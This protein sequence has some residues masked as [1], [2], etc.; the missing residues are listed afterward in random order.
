GGILQGA[1]VG[2]KDAP[3]LLENVILRTE[4][5][6]ENVI[7]GD[8]VKFGPGVT[9]GPNVR[10]ATHPDCT[11]GSKKYNALW[12]QI[13]ESGSCISGALAID[14]ET[15]PNHT[16]LTYT[17]AESVDIKIKMWVEPAHVDKA[18]DLFVLLTY[19]DLKTESFYTLDSQTWKS[20]DPRFDAPKAMR[21][22]EH[23]PAIAELPLF[24]GSLIHGPGEYAFYMGYRLKN[25][26]AV[27]TNLE[28]PVHFHVGNSLHAGTQS[29]AAHF[30]PW[31]INER[32]LNESFLENTAVGTQLRVDAKH[33][34]QAANLLMMALHKRRSEEVLYILYGEEWREWNASMGFPPA[35]RIAQ[36]P[37]ILDISVPANIWRSSPRE[38]L[39]FAGYQL[40]DGSII[41][42][43]RSP[44]HL[45]FAG[46]TNGTDET[47][48][49]FATWIHND[50]HPVNFRS[51]PGVSL[52]TNIA[53]DPR[54]IGQTADILLVA[55]YRDSLM[56]SGRARKW[57][58]WD[59]N[60]VAFSNTLSHVVL[61]DILYD[62]PVYTGSPANKKG[63]GNYVVYIGYRLSNGTIIYNGGETM[64]L[65]AH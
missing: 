63:A 32:G 18:A 28:E 34:G 54:H 29:A 43:G 10:L 47:L 19:T 56:H 65:G 3:A 17:Q 5:Y 15:M 11:A 53:V 39:I 13:G 37:E 35:Q 6:L 61:K 8:N 62:L 40:A 2:D 24:N 48:A 9:F 42:N 50:N 7:I 14:G 44:M 38:L 31:V 30:E 21:S 46:G 59:E 33:V 4:T 52:V 23:L 36:L 49:R 55:T 27:I 58:G 51:D 45:A 60:S 64:D 26:G 12:E 16:M 20:M 57:G 25:G 41:Y 1:V 22:Y